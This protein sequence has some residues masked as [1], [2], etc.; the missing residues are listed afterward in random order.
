MMM[1][2]KIFIN[3]LALVIL[4]GFS[5]PAHSML[6]DRGMGFIYD[7]DFDI[8]WLQDANYAKTSGYDSDG[9]M[10]WSDAMTWAD[11]LVYGRYDDWRLPTALN[12]NGNG[13]CLGYNCTDSELGSLYYIEL[14]NTAD[15]TAPYGPL[16]NSGP[17][18]NF[19]YDPF[20]PLPFGDARLFSYWTST[21]R[22]KISLTYAWEFPFMMG[23]QYPDKMSNTYYAW[24]VRDG[25]VVVPEPSTLLLLGFGLAGMAVW[26]KKI[27]LRKG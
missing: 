6:I 20:T 10:N 9:K 16:T 21:R 27:G 5:T 2:K 14:G 23:F 24:A 4:C 3:L 18:I 7:T 26:R 11:N 1:A 13:P 12:Q 8:T 25:N 17:F 15:N 19:P 22:D